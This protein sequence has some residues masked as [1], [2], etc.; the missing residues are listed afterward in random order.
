MRRKEELFLQGVNLELSAFSK[1]CRVWPC[2]RKMNDVDLG[3]RKAQ[4]DV[5]IYQASN[6]AIC[7][8]FNRLLGTC[9]DRS[10]GFAGASN[11]RLE[12]KG[13]IWMNKDGVPQGCC[14]LT[15]CCAK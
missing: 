3:T 7:K 13:C 11:T 4:N 1:I 2:R 8:C 9:K 5:A 15:T 12:L 14:A 10:A 6:V